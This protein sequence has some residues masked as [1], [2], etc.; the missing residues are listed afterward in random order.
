MEA[1]DACIAA[2]EASTDTPTLVS[3]KDFKSQAL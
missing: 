3:I 1:L 2:I